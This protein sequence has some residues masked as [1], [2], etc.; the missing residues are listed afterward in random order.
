MATR[1]YGG[2]TKL[3]ISSCFAPN[4]VRVVIGVMIK[5]K[6]FYTQNMR[7]SAQKS[8]VSFKGFI[9]IGDKLECIRNVV[10][11]DTHL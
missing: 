8:T 6:Y 4:R 11:W 5:K 10:I 2:E 7:V 9:R 1:L 3:I